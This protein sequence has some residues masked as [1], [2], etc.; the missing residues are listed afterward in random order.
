MSLNNFKNM[1]N[2][3]RNQNRVPP[4]GGGMNQNKRPGVEAAEENSRRMADKRKRLTDRIRR[5]EWS[6]ANADSQGLKDRLQQEIDALRAQ[7][8]GMNPSQIPVG[9]NSQPGPV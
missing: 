8:D 9:G 3:A 2:E 7:L 5:K 6:L 4:R 1:L